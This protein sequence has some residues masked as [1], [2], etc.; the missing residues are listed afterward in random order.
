MSAFLKPLTVDEFLAREHAEPLKHEFGGVQPVAIIGG[1]RAHSQVVT[2]L[3]VALAPLLRPPCEAFGP[4]LKV[5]TTRQV[6]YL[7]ASVMRTDGDG[8]SGTITP[9]VVFEV[10][11]PSTAVPH[12]RV[13]AARGPPSDDRQSRSIRQ[14]PKPSTPAHVPLTPRRARRDRNRP[15]T[16]RPTARR[17][18]AAPRPPTV[19]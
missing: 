12:R 8:S 9:A 11:S 17:T 4:D 7:D 15:P 10:L 19:R 2:R 3:I 1:T 5:L 6:R 14:A 13:K 16:P 18:G